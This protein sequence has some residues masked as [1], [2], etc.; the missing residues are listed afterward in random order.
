[1]KI[2]NV[3][4]IHALDQE[5]IRR[6]RITST[7]LMERAATR[8]T[9]WLENEFLKNFPIKK[10]FL[11]HIYCGT[12]NNGG[13]GLAICRILLDR[14]YHAMA[15]VI[16]HSPRVSEDFTINYQK[17]REIYPSSIADIRTEKDLINSEKDEIIIDAIFGSGLNKIPSGLAATAI[18]YINGLKKTVISIDVPSGLFCDQSTIFLKGSV[19]KADYTL[20]F[21][22]PKLAFMFPENSAFVGEWFIIPIDSDSQYLSQVETKNYFTTIDDIFPLI[23]KRKLFSHKGNYGHSLLICGSKGKIG[24]AVLSS[25]ACL[26]SGTGLLTVNIP[27]CGY[28]ILQSS[29]PEAMVISSETEEFLSGLPPLEKYNAIGIGPG[30]GLEKETQNLL[31]LLIQNTPVPLIIDADAINILAE[32]KTWLS[33]LPKGCIFTPHIG[34]FTRLCGPASTDFDRHQIQRE[35]SFKYQCFIVLKGANTCISTP[36]GNY[37]FNSTGNPG[38]AT[39]GS[40]DALTGIITSLCAQRYAPLS[41]CVTGVYLHGLAGDFA[42]TELSEHS[43]TATDIIDYIPKAFLYLSKETFPK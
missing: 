33:F 31:K 7:D 16:W 18:A 19:V 23:E 41:A 25:R 42:A 9:D 37:Y 39:G 21:E 27:A 10:Q 22:L 35:F 24:A 40:G 38:M 29:V 8:C 2:L 14:G 30:I 32:N 17:L 6:E 34:E 13:D 12:G 5:T 28:N 1:M 26:K 4:Q 3:V 20:T 36:E 15:S 11:F 43:V